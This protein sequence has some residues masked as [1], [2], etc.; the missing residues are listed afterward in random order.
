MRDPGEQHA[1]VTGE[2]AASKRCTA[3]S[4]RGPLEK[5]PH[6]GNLASGLP[7]HHHVPDR[8]CVL[9][10]LRTDT[11]VRLE[12]HDRSPVA[13]THRD[14]R[15]WDE[16]GRGLALIAQLTDKWAV[17]PEA[18]GKTVWCEVSIT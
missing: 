9:K 8:W 17:V 4:G 3:G 12:V 18:I 14:A 5:E 6:S 2:P 10:I 1:A 7:V 15:E 16:T 11:G 13:P